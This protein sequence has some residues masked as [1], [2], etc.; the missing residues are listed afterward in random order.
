ML[1]STSYILTEVR[2]TGSAPQRCRKSSGEEESN[3]GECEL[4]FGCC[5]GGRLMN[6]W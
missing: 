5:G 3:D 6:L 1:A 2:F 4:H